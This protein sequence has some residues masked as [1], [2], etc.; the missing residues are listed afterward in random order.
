MRHGTTGAYRWFLMQ[1]MPLKDAQSTVLKYVDTCTDI[2]ARKQ[3]EQRLKESEEHWHA[4]AETMPQIVWIGEPG[5]SKEYFNQRW[6]DYIHA[7]F[8][9]MRGAGWLQFLHPDD[10]ERTLALGRHALVTGEPYEIENRFKEGK[11]GMYRWF[12]SRALPVR[13]ET[14]QVV[15]WFG[16]CTDIEDQ[17]RTEEALC[18]SQEW[19]QALWNSPIIGIFLGQGE[20]V[21]EVNDTFL[22]M[23][24]YS[25]DD[26][27]NG[28]I[29]WGCM[30][31]PEYAVVTRSAHEELAL[32]QSMTSYEKGYVCQDGSRLPVV[33]GGVT[34][35]SNPFQ[36]FYFALDN[37]V[38]KELDLRKDAFISMA[39]HELRNPLTALKLRT[40][41]LHRQ[42]AKQGIPASALSSMETQINTVIRLVDELLDVS[43]IQAGRLEYVRE[44]VDLDVLLR[45]IADTLQQT[46]PSHTLVL[47][48]TVG[49]GLIGDRDRLG[50]VFTNLISNAIKYS[51]DAQTVEID[52]STSRETVTVS[53]CDHGLGIPREQRDKIFERFYRVADLKQ[54]AIPGLGMV[55]CH[56]KGKET[57]S[58]FDQPLENAVVLLDQV[59]EVFALPR[60]TRSGKIP[61]CLHFLEGFGI[62]RIFVNGDHAGSSRVGG[63]KGFCEETLGG[64]SVASGTQME[65]QRL[66]LRI[67]CMVQIHPHPF[68]LHRGLIYP[69]RVGRPSQMRT[70]ALLSLGC[71]VLHP[72]LNRGMVHQE[73]PFGHDALPD[74]DS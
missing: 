70:A 19:G 61:S 51:P 20:K 42:L 7:T 22:C 4:L 74:L 25:R 62:G 10:H 58:R 73:S 12:L 21:V 8:E 52:L 23:T 28:L 14:G 24:G 38:R 65:L 29:D 56:F 44:A 13:D 30:T 67:H 60:L 34:I 64:L 36:C 71:V 66:S 72:A 27:C 40:S 48:G 41:L 6:F 26:L 68:H 46:S 5:G 50:Q 15:K 11:T 31:P 32:H 59:F 47:R 17:K 69:P 35:P 43:K 2:E 63:D 49:T 33:V 3:T 57:Q 9:H 45:E 37:S 55:T 1:A 16:A 53:V 18:Q 54:K 39:S